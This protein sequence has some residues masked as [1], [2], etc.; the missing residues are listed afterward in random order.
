MVHLENL[1][2]MTANSTRALQFYF[3]RNKVKFDREPL[4]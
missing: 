2:A 4:G 1:F 3:F